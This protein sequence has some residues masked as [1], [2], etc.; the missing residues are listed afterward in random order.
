[1][2]NVRT[3]IDNAVIGRRVRSIWCAAGEVDLA[4]A[5]DGRGSGVSVSPWVARRIAAVSLARRFVVGG[6]G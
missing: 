3:K 2:R 5:L 6:H 4:A 1:V